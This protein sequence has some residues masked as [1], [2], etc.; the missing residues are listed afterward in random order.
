MVLVAGLDDGSNS[1]GDGLIAPLLATTAPDT[2]LQTLDLILEL[3]DDCMTLLEV[4]VEAIPLG[5]ELLLPSSESLLLDLDLLREPLAKGLFLLL[6]LGV[7]EL[8]RSGLA[9]LARLHLLGAVVFVVVLFGGVDEVEH[10]SADEDGAQLLEIA[11][12]FVFNLCDT[13]RVLTTLDGTAVCGGDVLFAADDGEGHGG[14]EG[15]GVLESGFVVLLKRGLVDFD[16]L[17]FDNAADLER[18]KC[19]VRVEDGGGEGER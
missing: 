12:V 15:L 16:A 18:E 13:P 6:E 3:L 11:V 9:K 19:N 10:V 4:L 7:V 2:T 17:G 14:D 5:N 8:S 1:A